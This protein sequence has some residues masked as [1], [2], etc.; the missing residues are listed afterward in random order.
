MLVS[1]HLPSL[2]Q[3]WSNSMSQSHVSVLLQSTNGILSHAARITNNFVNLG[4]EMNVKSK[5]K[6]KQI[7]R[8]EACLRKA[9]KNLKTVLGSLSSNTNEI[10]EARILHKKC[11]QDH[12]RIIRYFNLQNAIRRDETLNTILTHIPSSAH[13]SLK[14]SKTS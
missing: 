5:F 2:R 10:T 3:F 6:P 13:K 4:S 1:N 14:R 7:I 12:R 9:H 11:R 8:S